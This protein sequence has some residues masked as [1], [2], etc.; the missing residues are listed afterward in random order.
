MES[1]DEREP[2]QKGH[3]SQQMAKSKKWIQAEKSEA[4]R[5]KNFSSQLALFFT[6]KARKIFTKLRQRFVKA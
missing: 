3:K 2:T 4:A 1:G 5:A 6:F